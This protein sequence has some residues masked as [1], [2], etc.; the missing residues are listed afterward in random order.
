MFEYTK[1]FFS[2]PVLEDNGDTARALR[3]LNAVSISLLAFLGVMFLGPIFIYVKK[4]AMTMTMLIIVA[5]LLFSRTLALRDRI[6]LASVV[7][8]SGLWCLVTVTIWL[9]GGFNTVHSCGYIVLTVIAGMLLG[10]RAA[11]AVAAV[12]A[13]TGLGFAALPILGFNLPPYYPTPPLAALINLLCYF[14]LTVPAIWLAL[15]GFNDALSAARQEAKDRKRS[16]EALRES[17]EKYRALF[18]ESRDAVI[19][20]TRDGE[21]EA[22]NQA[23]LDLFGFT[24]E[25]A[26]NMDILNIYIDPAD[27]IRFQEDIERHGSLKDYEVTRRKKDG[28]VIEC[29]LTSTVRLEEDGT[30]VGYQ[31]IIRDVTEHKQL[32]RQL[33]QAQKMEAIGQL[34]GGV[35]HDF[36]NILTAIIGYSD[37][38]DSTNPGR[39]SI[40]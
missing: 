16:E 6:S 15:K 2:A 23:F 34:A 35:A 3:T 25:E 20:T 31:G 32:Q 11:L 29:L 26:E 1:Q 5:V 40:S 8:V 38:V 33:L 37:D 4:T 12:S 24:R 27:R 9:S 39:L 18:E 28:T 14:C 22:V 36:N 19:M 17:E 30:I 7:L 10:P 13:I 21:V